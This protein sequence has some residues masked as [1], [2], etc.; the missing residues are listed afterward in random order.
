VAGGAWVVAGA[1]EVISM[2]AMTSNPMTSQSKD[3]FF[4]IS[5]SSEQ[6]GVPGMT[7]VF[8]LGLANQRRLR[9]PGLIQPLMRPSNI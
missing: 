4:L 5:S 6:N 7:I 3:V 8:V 2:A 1:Q 9:L